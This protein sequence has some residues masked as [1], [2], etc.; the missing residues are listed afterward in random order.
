MAN[1]LP[2]R[3]VCVLEG[4]RSNGLLLEGHLEEPVTKS[5]I[6]T[7]AVNKAYSLAATVRI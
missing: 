5:L 4:R 6:V 2:P 3:R 1:Y 7:G